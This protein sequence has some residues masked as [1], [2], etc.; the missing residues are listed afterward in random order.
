MASLG[1]PILHAILRTKGREPTTLNSQSPLSRRGILRLA[2]LGSLTRPAWCLDSYA[3][4]A[5]G[6]SIEVSFQPGDFDASPDALRKWIADA[7][8]A[9]TTYFGRLPVP[10]TLLAVRPVPGRAGVLSGVTYPDTPPHTRIS[11]G[12]HAT[13]AE[14]D[15]DWTLTH[16]FSHLAFPNVPQQH[17]WMEEGMA[18]YVEPIARVQAGNLKPERIWADMV[19]DMPKGLPAPDS[20]GLDQTRSWANTYWGGAVFCLLA[21]VQYRERTHN[22]RG[23]Q[24]ALRG[25]LQAGGSIQEDWPITRAFDVADHAVGVPV[26]S[27]LYARM[28]D[29]AV[30][31]DLPDLWRRLGVSAEG[32]HVTFHNDA[33]LAAV[34]QAITAKPA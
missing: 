18:T 16:E 3:L 9:A 17:H 11:V 7:A 2:A 23:L 13:A 20:H 29:T 14:L 27:E 22:Q 33:E 32:R 12:Q 8:Q 26:L 1:L 25:I 19:R 28:K 10:R 34:R 15:D 4:P 30:P 31:T 6:G 24:H 5:G 21:D